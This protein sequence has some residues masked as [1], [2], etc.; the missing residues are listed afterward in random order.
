MT[1]LQGLKQGNQSSAVAQKVHQKARL[2]QAVI[3]TK[4]HSFLG[5]RAASVSQLAAVTTVAMSGVPVNCHGY[6]GT[7]PVILF[8]PAWRGD[9]VGGIQY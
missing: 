9:L 5:M 8:H 6:Q 4:C 7:L 1:Q 3:L 2:L